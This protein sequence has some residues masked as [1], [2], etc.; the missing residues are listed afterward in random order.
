V[1]EVQHAPNLF[2]QI[3]IILDES[4]KKGQFF[5]SGLQQFHMMKNVS[6]SLA[7]RLGIINL[8]GLSL[9]E[10][11]GTAFDEPFLPTDE[12]LFS[13]QKNKTDASYTDI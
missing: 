4:K 3:K 12:Y 5:L 10:M 9:R 8:T 2:P 13:R 7:G 11:H 6:E 1:D